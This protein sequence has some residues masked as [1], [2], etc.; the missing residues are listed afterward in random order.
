MEVKSLLKL[1]QDGDKDV[2]DKLV[3][4]NMGLI[5][6]VVKRFLKRGYDAQDLFQIGCIGLIKAIDKFD[7][8][9]DVTFSTYAVPMISGEIQRFLRDDGIIKI[10]RSIKENIYKVQKARE[11]IMKK[12]KQDATMNEIVIESGLTLEE[13]ITALDACIEVD[14]I[15]KPVYKSD[16]SEVLLIDKIREEK[17]GQEEVINNCLVEQMIKSLSDN[18]KLLI[19][20]RYFDD[21]TQK[22]IALKMGMSQV[23]VSRMEKKIL[24]KLRKEY[25]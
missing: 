11:E 15:Y 19:K 24:T 7:L 3:S 10:S 20:Y 12:K 2:R 5:W 25:S 1:A 6:S 8:S 14:T 23:Q 18:E 9:Y 21:K 17:N 22:E 4:D 16:D 13:V